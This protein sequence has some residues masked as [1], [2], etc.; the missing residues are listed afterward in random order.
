MKKSPI[1]VLFLFCLTL[2]SLILIN[3][4]CITVKGQT[5]G[6]FRLDR[7]NWQGPRSPGASNTPVQF[8]IMNLHNESITSI[9]G[10]LSLSSP[11]TDAV[12]GDSNATSVGEALST[13]FNVSQYVVLAGEPFEFIFN[14]DIDNAA[15]KG[16]SPANLT[17]TYFYRSGVLPGTPV[18]FPIELNIPNTPPEVAWIS[19]AVGTLFVEKN[20][21]IN[22]SVICFDED[23]DS[24]EYTWEVDN[25][26][27]INENESSL[28]FSTQSQVGVQEISLYISD[29]DSIISRTWLVETQIESETQL[30]TSTQYLHA[31]TKT[32][33]IIN[34]T[35]NL[36]KGNIDIQLQDPAPLIVEGDSSWTFSNISEGE[37]LSFPLTIFTPMAAMGSTGAAV[38]AVSFKDQHGTNYVEFISVGLIVRGLVHVSV[39]SSEI[40]TQEIQQGETVIISAT[41][42]NTGN[43][44]ALF[45]NTSLM[46]EEGVLIETAKS[47]SY[48]GEIEP[49]SP[50]PFS[51]SANINSSA[52]AGEHQV[53]CV[54][55]YQDDLYLVHTFNITFT[56]NIITSSDTSG[57]NSGLNLDDLALGSGIAIVLGGGTIL[58]VLYVV[59]RKK[60]Q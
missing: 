5:V 46:I 54:V 2:L 30:N 59:F 38:F 16:L 31:G 8:E 34:L 35:N 44:N 14:L 17:I 3:E 25:T 43:V 40:S 22:F 6:N 7:I 11:F 50:L 41:L 1:L 49:D 19:P 32:D 10:V 36:W 28:L 58:A 15:K 60:G 27:L 42:L 13:Y 9:F 56:I 33:F 52:E 51:I 48:L 21:L 20:D 4:P 39:F 53:V 18:V 37:L 55:Y 29:N 57:T 24:L 45:T 12:G 23:N 47:K 26:P